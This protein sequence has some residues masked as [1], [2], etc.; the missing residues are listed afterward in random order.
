MHFHLHLLVAHVLLPQMGDA[1]ASIPTVQPAYG[2]PM[3]GSFPGSAARNSYAFV[4]QHAFDKNIAALYG[5]SKNIA[6]VTGC[7]SV[8]KKCMKW[9]DTLP[10]MSVDPESYEVC[11]DGVLADVEPAREVPLA[12]EYNLF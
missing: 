8:T 9:N 2:R 12:R 10:E 11:A 5:L 4:S 7:R 3:W 1:N 6:P